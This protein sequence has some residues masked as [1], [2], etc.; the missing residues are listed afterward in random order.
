VLFLVVPV[1]RLL[2]QELLVLNDSREKRY[3]EY[4]SNLRFESNL[5]EY[6]VRDVNENH[7]PTQ[8]ILIVDG[9][10]H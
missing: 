2:Q 8:S 10:D 5:R 4:D 6:F 3:Y 7:F 1:V 9:Q